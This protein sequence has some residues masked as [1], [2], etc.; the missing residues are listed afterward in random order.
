[1]GDQG[2]ALFHSG[3]KRRVRQQRYGPGA[4][5]NFQKAI[6]AGTDPKVDCLVACNTWGEFWIFGNER[7]SSL[8]TNIEPL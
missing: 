8:S 1:V 6:Q 2:R 7:R 3:R 5:D 4:R